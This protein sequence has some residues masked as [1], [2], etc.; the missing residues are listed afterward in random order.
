MQSGRRGNLLSSQ[1]S[2]KKKYIVE[3][4]EIIRGVILVRI[5]GIATLR[6]Q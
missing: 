1:M 6:S 2:M 4:G 5:V 3:R